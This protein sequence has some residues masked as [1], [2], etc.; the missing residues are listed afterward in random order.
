MSAFSTF[1]AKQIWQAKAEAKCNFFARLLLHNRVLTADNMLKRNWDFNPFYPFC[2]CMHET[3]DHLFSQ[4][5]YT[6]ETWNLLAPKFGLW[7]FSDIP[8]SNSL[9]GWTDFFLSSSPSAQ[10]KMRLGMLFIFWWQT[11]KEP[12][13]RIFNRRSCH[14]CTFW[15]SP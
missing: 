13:R 11:W 10:K 3:S 6:E 4:C 9:R 14:I 2:M 5:N 12:N 15:L 1:P 8:C 7:N